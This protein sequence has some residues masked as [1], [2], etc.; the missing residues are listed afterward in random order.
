MESGSSFDMSTIFNWLAGAL[1]ALAVVVVLYRV[2]QVYWGG[3]AKAEAGGQIQMEEKG[4]KYLS[5]V[6]DGAAFIAIVGCVR[7]LLGFLV[8]WFSDGFGSFV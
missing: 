5:Q 6:M 2:W 1:A 7:G 3:S 4:K 8:G